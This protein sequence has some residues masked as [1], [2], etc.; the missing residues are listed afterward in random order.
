MKTRIRAT[1]VLGLPAVVVCCLLPNPAIAAASVV[2]PL[3][4]SNYQVRSACGTPAPGNAGCLAQ[5]LVPATAAARARLHPLGMVRATPLAAPTPAE[6]AYGLRPED[7]RDAYFSGEAPDAP[8]SE[9]QTIALIEAYNDLDAEADLNTYSHEF[10]IPE[11]A[12]CTTGETSDCF[13]QVNEQGSTETKELPFPQTLGE[14]KA[15]RKLCEE[16]PTES[17]PIE[18]W[19][20]KEAA[21]A[22]VE[23]ATGWSLET[24]LDIE[25]AHA[26]CQNCRIVIVEAENPSYDALEEAEETAA[27]PASSGGVG[28]TEI[29]NSWDGPEP[30]PQDGRAEAV[31]SAAFDHPGIVIAAAAG[32]NGY[33]NWTE[34]EEAKT[35]REPYYAGADY[36]ASSPHVVAVGGTSL[37]LS[38]TGKWQS[39]AV[40][41]DDHN[42]EEPNDGAGGSGCS[43]SFQAPAWQRSLPNWSAVG[44]ED[45]RAVA[46]V[47]AD[48]DPYTGVAVYD[49]ESYCEYEYTERGKDY[50]VRTPWCTVG[51]TSLGTPLIAAMYALA[52][53]AHGVEYP[54][55]T[56]YE[57]LETGVLH[58][59][60]GANGECDGDYA[61]GCTGSIGPQSPRFAFDCGAGVLICNAAAGCEGDFYSGP[62]G[63]GT[64]NGIG[65][66]RHEQQP[67][68]IVPKCA[69]T[70]KSSG[71]GEPEGG[72]ETGQPPTGTGDPSPAEGASA[73]PS[74]TGATGPSASPTTPPAAKPSTIRLTALALTPTALLALDHPRSKISSIAFA[75]TLSAAARVRATLAKLVRAHGRDRW[76]SVPGALTFSAAKGRNRRHLASPGTLASGRYRLTLAPLG[77]GA[78][79]LTLQIG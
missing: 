8:A 62:T 31:D 71:A 20:E 50:V 32:D 64:P 16:R 5:E 18:E 21:C 34:A 22:E 69:A 28:A 14:E 39:E 36:P 41:N 61:S 44:C 42:S 3:P 24:S 26:T 75:F 30:E 35:L 6:G 78:Q 76:V 47:S 46:D 43:T 66:F 38:R 77:G 17:E 1:A 59:V 23:E 29:S 63:V 74:S 68:I 11:L 27:K 56:L 54:A 12:P 67:A 51:G 48:G 60:T 70:G 2:S 9:P 53:G 58:T 72:G 73:D 13:E 65:A 79:T 4:E 52:G 49:S 55:K 15:A 57:H 25:I 37:T 45:R 40:W 33:L 19:E 10:G 7:L